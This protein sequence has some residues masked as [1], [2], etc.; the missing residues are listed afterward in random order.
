M[1]HAMPLAGGRD[2]KRISLNIQMLIVFFVFV[3]DQCLK[4]KKKKEKK[5]DIS[6]KYYSDSS[7]ICSHGCLSIVFV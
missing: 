5:R 4:F 1:L 6:V 3:E 2:L 7:Q